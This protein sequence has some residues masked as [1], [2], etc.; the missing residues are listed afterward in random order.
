M[1]CSKH[2]Q[3]MRRYEQILKL[4]CAKKIFSF[5]SCVKLKELRQ[6]NI[7]PPPTTTKSAIEVVIQKIQTYTSKRTTGASFLKFT[8]PTWIEDTS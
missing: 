2:F 8:Y 4:G 5:W 1:N 6:L 3:E 7:V